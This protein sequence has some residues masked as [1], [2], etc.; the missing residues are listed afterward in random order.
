MRILHVL[1]HS[2]PEASGYSLRSHSIILEQRKLGWSTFHVTSPRHRSPSDS[3]ESVGELTFYRTAAS[4]RRSFVHT[5]F[6]FV[7]TVRQ[8]RRRLRS[9]I[10][11]VRPDIIHAHSPC[12]NGLAALGLGRPVVYEM[13]TLWED[14]SIL[15]GRL[16]EGSLSHKLARALETLVLRRAAAVVT[17]SKGLRTEVLS[18]GVPV[19]RVTIIANAVDTDKLS[20]ERC[21]GD[22]Q[23][24]RERFSLRDQ[25]ILGYVGSLF[26]WEGLELLLRALC[27][28][29]AQ[30]PDVGLLVV[31]GGPQEN[32]LKEAAG[33]LGIAEHVIFTGRVSPE[34]AWQA[35]D[36]IDILVYPRLAMRLTEIVTPLKPLE[37]MAVGKP[38]I[39]SDVGGHRELVR[40]QETGV[41]FRAGNQDALVSAILRV[42]DDGVL[43]E[44]L[45]R[46][47]AKIVREERSW[48]RVVQGYE[49]VYR[50]LVSGH[51]VVSAG[52]SKT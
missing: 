15:A 33:R 35:Y 50:S 34:V 38:L 2:L 25:Y 6:D 8:L 48:A 51:Q 40:D 3:H 36:A 4:A 52:V 12:S 10:K 23:S 11:E 32:E 5:P 45:I 16:A 22:R 17:I 47:G 28:V 19:N 31:G 24:A 20:R 29:R 37:A 9:I 46:D 27:D 18:R 21:L 39:A 14:G 41:L 1:D 49:P 7:H 13:R 44:R 30:N 43:R 26:P 42:R